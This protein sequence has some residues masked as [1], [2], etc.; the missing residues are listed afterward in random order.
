MRALQGGLLLALISSLPSSFAADYSI[1][2]PMPPRFSHLSEVAPALSPEV[3]AKATAGVVSII[4]EEAEGSGVV[5]SS[6]ATRTLVVTNAHVVGNNRKVLVD[7]TSDSTVP[8]PVVGRV[9][10]SDTAVDLSLLEVV[11]HVQHPTLPLAE[12]SSFPQGYPMYAVGFPRGRLNGENSGAFPSVS[13]TSGFNVEPGGR[14]RR[15]AAYCLVGVN[16]GNSGGAAIDAD[17]R[18]RGIISAYF[19]TT[20]RTIVIP[21]ED[22]AEFLHRVDPSLLFPLETA[23][24]STLLRSTQT[25]PPPNGGALVLVHT[26]TGAAVGVVIGA[27]GEGALVATDAALFGPMY[28]KT[29]VEVSRWKN[30]EPDFI[31]RARVVVWE[32]R[33]EVALVIVDSRMK[34]P[35]LTLSTEPEQFALTQPIGAWVLDIEGKV[36][37]QHGTISAIWRGVESAERFKVDLGIDRGRIGGLVFDMNGRVLGLSLLSVPGTNITTLVPASRL[38]AMKHGHVRAA[39]FAL[40]SDDRRCS[41]A[42]TVELYDPFLT[43][44]RVHLMY[45]D[46]PTYEPAWRSDVPPL[47]AEVASVEVV[48]RRAH[49]K[50]IITPCRQGRPS[51]QLA[52]SGNG[53]FERTPAFTVLAD[54][55]PSSSGVAGRYFP[56]PGVPEFER[57]IAPELPKLPCV[58][59]S[60]WQCH[61]ECEHGD[62]QACFRTGTA[63]LHPD[64]N[65]SPKQVALAMLHLNKACRAGLSRACEALHEKSPAIATASPG[66]LAASE[67][68]RGDLIACFLWARNGGAFPSMNTEGTMQMLCLAGVANACAELHQPVEGTT[69]FL[70]PPEFEGLAIDASADTGTTPPKP[71]TDTTPVAPAAIPGAI[72]WSAD[73]PDM[74]DVG[75][76]YFSM[77]PGDDQAEAALR[78]QSEYVARCVL[79]ALSS[80][81]EWMKTP[82][83]KRRKAEIIKGV[84]KKPG[85]IEPRAMRCL[86]SLGDTAAQH[87][88]SRLTVTLIRQ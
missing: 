46:R 23:R 57:P 53:F 62:L 48:D 27:T 83:G 85:M 84:V 16:P 6:D 1:S 5:L 18:V 60:L 20:E 54:A 26:A 43:V 11:D 61:L 88:V 45:A 49:I 8:R 42:A 7:F 21:S 22:V 2:Q 64:V 15:A 76:V 52:V 73:R 3:V 87:A 39:G 68:P 31:G 34:L 69:S 82:R 29:P 74:L 81:D 32:P 66:K 51:L 9:V 59:L 13:I 12:W 4:T 36:T 37:E 50:A 55:T 33:E 67:C 25:A 77:S 80:S 35:I 72:E 14:P 58:G 24:P 10:F 70:R 38:T 86:N 79:V 75:I 63:M 19:P 56:G 78:K 41:V 40:Q 47:G 71:P 28:S 44:K 65:P 17:G 30:G